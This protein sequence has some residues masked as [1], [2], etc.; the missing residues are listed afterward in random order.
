[1]AQGKKI[2]KS[3]FNC[4]KMLLKGGATNKEVAEFLQ[5]SDETVRRIKKAETYEEYLNISYA[6]S[7][8]YYKKKRIA[9]EAAAK[10]AAEEEAARKAEEEAKKAEAAKVAETVGAVPAAQIVPLQAK[11]LDKPISITIQAT[12]Y[13]ETKLDK[14][15]ELLT[16]I[17]AKLAAI[18]DDLYGTGKAADAK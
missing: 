7:G 9:E 12:H 2:T 1:M 6:L 17:S 13:M 4:A 5:I 10:K 8:A 16:C 11:P 3:A 18:I 15:N 14:T